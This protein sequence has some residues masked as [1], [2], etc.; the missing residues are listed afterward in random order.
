MQPVSLEKAGE[1]ILQLRIEIPRLKQQLVEPLER[2]KLLV[3]EER[4]FRDLLIKGMIG[5]GVTTLRASAFKACIVPK[6]AVR[7]RVRRLHDKEAVT[8]FLKDLNV[9][10]APAATEVLQT[11]LAKPREASEFTFIIEKA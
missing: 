6:K 7:R 4:Q 2:L 3:Q 1:L 11:L 5:R 8:S 9:K 10:N